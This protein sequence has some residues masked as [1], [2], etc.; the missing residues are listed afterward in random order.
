M[1]PCSSILNTKGVIKMARHAR[2][3]VWLFAAVMLQGIVGLGGKQVI[4][5]SAASSLRMV[6]YR[7][8]STSLSRASGESPRKGLTLSGGA[9]RG[10]GPGGSS[11]ASPMSSPS[12]ENSKRIAHDTM[13]LYLPQSK[14]LIP[15]TLN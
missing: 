11:M 8:C 3:R 5:E 14:S 15:H 1:L 10:G 4:L 13:K 7:R 9:L 12:G 2:A 6:G